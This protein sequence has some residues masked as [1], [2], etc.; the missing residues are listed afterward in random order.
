MHTTPFSQISLDKHYSLVFRAGGF[1]LGTLAILAVQHAI[2]LE[3]D[4]QLLLVPLAAAVLITLVGIGF[5]PRPPRSRVMLDDALARL[6]EGRLDIAVPHVNDDGATG[7]TARAVEELRRRLIVARQ[8]ESELTTLRAEVTTLRDERARVRDKDQA[9][10]AQALDYIKGRANQLSAE[11]ETLRHQVSLS[12]EAGRRPARRP[13]NGGVQTAAAAAV[14]LT[15]SISEIG[16]QLRQGSSIAARAVREVQATS[17]LVRAL[18]KSSAKIGEVIT[19][20]TAIAEQTN[21]LA[22]NAT[23]EAARAGEAGR[24]FAVV[25]QEVKA[26]ANQTARATDE[27]R[28][29]I[30]DMQAATAQAVEAIETI[31]GTIASIDA[32]TVTIAEAVSQQSSATQEIARSIEAVAAAS[33]GQEPED[34]PAGTAE[35]DLLACIERLGDLVRDLGT[36]AGAL[37]GEPRPPVERQLRVA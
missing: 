37:A 17:E 18:D 31:S 12:L 9:N 1:F 8:Q 29:Q 28:D 22:L 32:M 36:Q 13:L 35:R 23:I 5:A 33:H 11:L 10:L 6:A 2:A 34:A 27:I 20:I 25:A 3:S 7:R 4:E 15:S 30:V 19:L 16:R 26:L 14:E 21:L 24:G